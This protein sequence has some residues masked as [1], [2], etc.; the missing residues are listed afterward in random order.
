M[1]PLKREWIPFKDHQDALD[2]YRRWGLISPSAT[3]LRTVMVIDEPLDPPQPCQIVGYEIGFE[4]WVVIELNG[5]YSA[6][7]CDYLVDMQPNA[8]QPTPRG[9]TFADILAHYA[10]LDIS[11]NPPCTISAAIFNYGQCERSFLSSMDV[12]GFEN[13]LRSFVG[14]LPIVC[15][16]LNGSPCASLLRS[17]GIPNT[18]LSVDL[19]V[20]KVFPNLSGTSLSYLCDALELEP[21]TNSVHSV[22]ALLWSCLSF[23]RYERA[24]RVACMNERVGKTSRLPISPAVSTQLPVISTPS[25][26]YTA[27]STTP[28]EYVVLD[29]ET[30]GFDRYNDRI[31]EIAAIKFHNGK[32]TDE[33]CSLVNPFCTLR[34][35]I[36][37]LTGIM[38][39]EVDAA[40]S[41]NEIKPT[42]LAFIGE[43]PLVGHNI[44][45]FDSKFIEAQMG[46]SFRK[47]RLID[48]LSLAKKAYPG[49]LQYKLE[50][51]NKALDL[52]STT[53]HR[54]MADVEATARLYQKCTHQNVTVEDPSPKEMETYN[55]LLPSL[56]AVLE[57]N[58]APTNG[59]KPKGGESY[60]SVQYLK[61]DPYDERKILAETLVFRIC[62]RE[63]YRY[64]G[65]SNAYSHLF[66]EDI[67][68]FIM[69]E[70]SDASFTNFA[71]SLEPDCMAKYIPFLSA[72]LDAA[73]A[74]LPKEYDCCSRYEECSNAMR[75]IHPNPAMAIGCGYRRIM[76]SG[77][78]FYG[79]NRNID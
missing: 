69:S 32:K 51:L 43:L 16:E 11:T 52:G 2:H 21:G 68:A 77:R 71:F 8:H 60:A 53:S 72:I 49:L 45:A 44:K 12:P 22:N 20:K 35:K 14:N 64:F 39:M 28:E 79:K 7:H 47:D 29:I 17:V 13:D 3:E 24:Y 23:R 65:V 37:K 54:A 27:T 66:T 76:K 50:F 42:F 19:M 30:T 10:V 59:I 73:I 31:I 62:Y 48:T 26:S 6:I 58:N 1:V 5:T 70:T 9:V 18:A 33:F 61:F 75:C 78:I 63:N 40:P 34:P 38:Q 74:T 56:R 55:L 25:T 46:C 67:S 15:Y 36:T 4:N 57:N 41:L